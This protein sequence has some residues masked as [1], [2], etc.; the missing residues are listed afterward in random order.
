M[1]PDFAVVFNLY[2]LR[3]LELALAPTRTVG[4]DFFTL[5]FFLTSNVIPPSFLSPSSAIVFVHLSPRCCCFVSANRFSN[6]PSP[7]GEWLRAFERP[8]ALSATA[9]D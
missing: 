6:I 5:Y 3:A 9:Y 7:L 2:P 4:H 8:S 1:R